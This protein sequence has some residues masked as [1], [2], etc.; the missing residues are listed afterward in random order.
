MFK[1]QPK[2]EKIQSRNY[3]GPWR[4]TPGRLVG[5]ALVRFYQITFSSLI[6]NQCRHMPSCSEYTYEAIA[7]YGL[8]A[9]IWMGLFRVI[10][11]GPF[12]THGIDLVPT[13]LDNSYYFYKPWR[14]WKISAKNNK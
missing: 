6:G 12:G 14:Y 1:L 9:G 11:C 8:W 4:K 7:R 2:Q 13:S 5:A 3:A 10:R